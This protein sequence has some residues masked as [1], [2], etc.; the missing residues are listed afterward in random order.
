MPKFTQKEIE[1]SKIASIDWI[2]RSRIA[3]T[4]EDGRQIISGSLLMMVDKERRIS[5]G[6]YYTESGIVTVPA[7]FEA[8]FSPV[9]IA[10]S[11]SKIQ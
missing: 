3:F 2:E 10:E 11:P 9:A 7:E 5:V 6:D 8:Q 4:L 1:A